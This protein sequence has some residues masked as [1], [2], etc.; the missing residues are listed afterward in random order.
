V[1]GDGAI[2]KPQLVAQAQQG[3]H[4]AAQKLSE[5]IVQHLVSTAGVNQYQ[6][7]VYVFVNKRGLA[8]AFGRAGHLA[9]KNKFEEFI[10]GFNQAAGR[11]IMVDAGSVKEAADAKIKGKLC[12]NFLSLRAL[13]DLTSLA[14]LEDEIRLP[15]TERIIF[16]GTNEERLKFIL[17][18][19]IIPAGCHDNGYVTTIR[20]QITAGFKHKL[21]LLQGYSDM[22]TGI[23][24]LDL[25]SFSIPD[26][27]ML[28]KLVAPP[29]T[30]LK[31][32]HP[33][34]LPPPPTFP[35]Q[36]SS[37]LGEETIIPAGPLSVH[38]GF[39][40][41][42]FASAEPEV[43]APKPK[44]PPSYSSAVQTGAPKR[45]ITPELDSSGSTSSSDGSDE[46]NYRASPTNF[47][48][49]RV[50]PNIVG[51]VT[52]RFFLSFVTDLYSLDKALSKRE[53]LLGVHSPKCLPNFR[54]ATSV[55]PFL[56]INV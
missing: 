10:A 9:A 12:R 15:Q 47:K 31:N 30:Q 39:D 7:W 44:S 53:Y 4:A 11:F 2:F 18:I 17:N 34:P 42:P 48:S 35:V 1:D 26:L 56:F 23:K 33:S 41:L 19:T 55:H 50:N 43:V 25:P 54:Q 45:V 16:G 40:A 21:I 37:A 5:F 27:F 14:I 3:G 6:L 13:I 52:S 38:E 8:E 22:A 29:F 24:E 28:E 51:V 32:P 46:L 36:L 49:R 20:S